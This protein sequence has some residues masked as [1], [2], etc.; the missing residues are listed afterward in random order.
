MLYSENSAENLSQSPTC[1][2]KL[3]KWVAEKKNN[4]TLSTNPEQVSQ[5]NS[6]L[7]RIDE[8]SDKLGISA[9]DLEQKGGQIS[10]ISEGLRRSSNLANEILTTLEQRFGKNKLESGSTILHTDQFGIIE[11]YQSLKDNITSFGPDQSGELY[12]TLQVDNRVLN[13]LTSDILNGQV[14]D[15]KGL[16]MELTKLKN[17]KNITP[18][19]PETQ[20]N[21]Q[22]N[23]KSSV[24][25]D[26]QKVA[27]IQNFFGAF[28]DGVKEVSQAK[29][30]EYKQRIE[31]VLRGEELKTGDLKHAEQLKK[32]YLRFGDGSF[33]D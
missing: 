23:V 7:V 3:Y 1:A 22:V 15:I 9:E 8:I 10:H 13:G 2:E 33:W 12:R 17:L 20:R 28:K 16:R 27:D 30:A 24:G 11:T 25:S 31:A 18:P 26:Q 5:L 4:D 14:T 32:E 19:T 29:Q 6:Q 21:K